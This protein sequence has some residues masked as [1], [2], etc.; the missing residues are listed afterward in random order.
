MAQEALALV[1]SKSWIT[2]PIAGAT[3]PAR[4]REAVAALDVKLGGDE[5]RALEAPC[6]PPC[7]DRPLLKR[8][9]PAALPWRG[10]Q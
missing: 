8:R 4:V 5:A 9:G 3:S 10:F 6:V 2:A 1:L 7:E